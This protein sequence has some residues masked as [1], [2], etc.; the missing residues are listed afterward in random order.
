MK[1]KTHHQC[2]QYHPKC[3]GATLT[4]WEMAE[5]HCWVILLPDYWGK[6]MSLPHPSALM[7]CLIIA[8]NDG[9]GQTGIQISK[10]KDH[11]NF[12]LH[13]SCFH[14]VFAAISRKSGVG[15]YCPIPMY[16]E[17]RTWSQRRLFSS[18]LEVRDGRQSLERGNILCVMPCSYPQLTVTVLLTM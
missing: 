2:E 15:L 1:G 3:W 12:S 5:E 8:Q 6:H 17:V 7:S 11:N 4:N 13:L 10:T 14:Q 16:P 18:L 9:A